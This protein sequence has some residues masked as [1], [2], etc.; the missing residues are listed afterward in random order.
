[1]G[2]G[3]PKIHRLGDDRPFAT[4]LDLSSALV[5]LPPQLEC[6]L[7]RIA[8]NVGNWHEAD[9]PRDELHVRV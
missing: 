9:M 1:M 2:A 7:L 4:M 5:R 6:R 8:S 3:A